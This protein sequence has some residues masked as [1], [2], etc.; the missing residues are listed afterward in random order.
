VSRHSALRTLARTA[1][2]E[3]DLAALRPQVGDDVDLQWFVLQRRAELG[4]VDT[5]AV[6]ALQERDPDPEAWVRALRVRASAP[7]PEAKEEA[8]TALVERTAPIQTAYSV[9]E[10]FWRPGQ[11]EVLA[12]YAERYLEALPTLH[13]G[14]MIPGLTL[15]MSL[16]PVYAVDEAWIGHA[17]EVAAAKAAPVVVGSLTERSEEVLRMVRARAL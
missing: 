17:R 14:G 16:F 4:T 7:T 1:A 13:E 10:A 2:G 11:D 15:A 12:P 3:E 5:D 6:Q 8:W 9:S